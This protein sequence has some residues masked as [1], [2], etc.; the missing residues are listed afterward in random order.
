MPEETKTDVNQSG[1]STEQST[2]AGAAIGTDDSK[3]LETPEGDTSKAAEGGDKA[4]TGKQEEEETDFEAALF[5]TE[6]KKTEGE[7][8]AKTTDDTAAAAKSTSIG[9]SLKTLREIAAQLDNLPE[10]QDANFNRLRKMNRTLVNEQITKFEA[11]EKLEAYGDTARVEQAL[12]LFDG[13]HGY[14]TTNGQPSAHK[15]AESLVQ[16]DPEIAYNAALNIMRHSTKD[17]KPFAE[18]FTRHVLGI[19]P[20]RLKDFQAISKGE[21]PEGYEGF[22]PKAEE[23]QIIPTEFHD[24]YKR[25]TPKLRE[26]VNDGF[27]Q[28][29]T[30]ADKT[31]AVRLLQESQKVISVDRQKAEDATKQEETLRSNLEAKATE[32]EAAS[33]ETIGTRINSGLDK[34]AFS[35]DEAVDLTMKQAVGNQIFNL[36]H[37]APFIRKSAEEY[38]TKMGVDVKTERPKIDYWFNRLSENIDIETVATLKGQAKAAEEAHRVRLQ[39]ETQLAAI[40]LKLIA[41]VARKTKAGLVNRG[42]VKLPENVIP[43][44]KT[45]SQATQSGKVID[46]KSAAAATR[47]G[48][49]LRP[50]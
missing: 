19:D 48:K 21:I 20:A 1:E 28:Y 38:F 37:E 8:G 16:Q 43:A 39:A 26:I 25:L 35:S 46:Y 6:E 33:T 30:Q 36:V 15:F 22:V 34:I 31:E 13:L 9:E 14:D 4:D 50:A 41:N 42:S 40:G 47:E 7:E 49:V 17:G 23:L 27:D 11:A 45:D 10:S 29:A 12:N 5:D 44:P 32:F 2:D 3:K 24:A 18:V